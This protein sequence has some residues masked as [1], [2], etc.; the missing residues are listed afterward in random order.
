MLPPGVALCWVGEAVNE[1][2]NCATGCVVV[3]TAGPTLNVVLMT[4]LLGFGSLFVETDQ[5][6]VC[7]PGVAIHGVC[8]FTV[9]GLPVGP[10]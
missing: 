10:G 4:L 3:D 8:V 7:V 1:K 2:S 6:N 9:A 5:V